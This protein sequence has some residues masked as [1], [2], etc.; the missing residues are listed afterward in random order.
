MTDLPGITH[1]K[2]D[3]SMNH[4]ET[5]ANALRTKMWT[6]AGA[7]FN[8]ARRL[9]LRERCSTFS[10]AL[11]SLVAIAAGL[12][13][14]PTVVVGDQRGV[15]ID[16]AVVTSMISVFILIISLVEG[17]SRYQVRSERIHES[18]SRLGNL[19]ENLELAIAKSKTSGSPDYDSVET[20]SKE[21][22]AEIDS[23]P[24]NHD[25]IDYLRFNAAHRKS[26]EFQL[27][28]GRPRMSFLRA[29]GVRV[30]YLGSA[31]WLSALSWSTV[32]PVYVWLLFHA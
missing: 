32:V 11:L 8:A 6:T 10:I 21:Y 5:H 25:P 4:F 16:A 20:L 13:G 19:R 9:S 2:S 29:V 22:Q 7:R 24:Y 1:F 17:S 15:T 30:G 18:A 23:C 26:S 31:I 3:R 14:L 12:I 28:S 27:E